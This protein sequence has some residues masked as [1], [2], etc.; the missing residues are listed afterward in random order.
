MIRW[1]EQVAYMGAKRNLVGKPLLGIPKHRWENIIKM[2]L[3]GI[4][5]SSKD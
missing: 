2:D 4:E 1:V 5:Y 3:R